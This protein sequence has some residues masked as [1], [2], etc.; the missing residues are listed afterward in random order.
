MSLL[1]GKLLQ[2]EGHTGSVLQFS[3]A[4]YTSAEVSPQT[5]VVCKP[6]SL[7][8]ALALIAQLLK[9]GTP[10]LWLLLVFSVLFY[11]IF[12]STD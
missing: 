8:W 3:A 5:H 6:I 10:R 1:K 4:P 9:L 11:F 2:Q 12:T 7:D